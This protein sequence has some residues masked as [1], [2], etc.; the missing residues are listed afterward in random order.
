M[1]YAGN[2]EVCGVDTDVDGIPDMELPCE[3]K[4]CQKVCNKI[5]A[6]SVVLFISQAMSS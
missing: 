4:S 3:E 5:S 2:G 6:L 1:G